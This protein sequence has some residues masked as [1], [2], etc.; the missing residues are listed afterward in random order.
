MGFENTCLVLGKFNVSRIIPRLYEWVYKTLRLS[1]LVTEHST[2]VM[3]AGL[4]SMDRQ[5]SIPIL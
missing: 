3:S 4:N 2:V 5:F 1:P